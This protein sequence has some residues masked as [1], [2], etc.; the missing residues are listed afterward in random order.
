MCSHGGGTHA[1]VPS[2]SR[3]AGVQEVSWQLP[4]PR[5]PQSHCQ[6][7]SGLMRAM[8]GSTSPP[9]I[10]LTA[11]STVPSGCRHTRR[12][13]VQSRWMRRRV[14]RTK[15]GCGGGATAGA[16]GRRRVA[17]WNACSCDGVVRV[18]S[19]GSISLTCSM[20]Q[21]SA[22]GRCLLKIQPP[23]LHPQVPSTFMATTRFLSG[24]L[25]LSTSHR[26]IHTP[27]ASSLLGMFSSPGLSA[28]FRRCQRD[29]SCDVPSRQRPR[30]RSRLAVQARALPARGTGRSSSPK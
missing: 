20:C 10:L 11:N 6:V 23:Q 22:R 27:F 16:P 25:R 2:A 14:W 19:T 4:V 7:L 21:Q 26:A 5:A 1:G 28:C 9:L 30:R 18:L 3:D 12:I 15:Y 13:I 24:S 29:R 8:A 17:D